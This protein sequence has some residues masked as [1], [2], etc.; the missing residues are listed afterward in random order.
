MI[1]GDGL[2]IAVEGSCNK[3]KQI[4]LDQPMGT[5]MEKTGA[6]RY[7]R[8]MKWE[9]Q[10]SWACQDN[11]PSLQSL[12]TAWAFLCLG[13]TPVPLCSLVSSR[14]EQILH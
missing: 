7:A 8:R 5:W 9:L 12:G 4:A 13:Q 14:S 3:S 11:L 6:S 1:K 10:N 2:W